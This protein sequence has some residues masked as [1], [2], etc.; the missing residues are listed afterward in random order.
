[1]LIGIDTSLAILEVLRGEFGGT[2]Y[3]PAPLL[4]RLADSGRT[5]RKGGAGFY[6][7]PPQ[8]SAPVSSSADI[9]NV[10]LPSAPG[11]VTL[12]DPAGGSDGPGTLA[13]DLASTI[14]AAGINVTRSPAHS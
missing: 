9:F 13:A 6:D 5:G 7:Y 4:R 10:D 11:T 8:G 1:D 3:T 12:I 2:R 14:A